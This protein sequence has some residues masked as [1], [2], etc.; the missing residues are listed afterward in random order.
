MAPNPFQRRFG[1]PALD[2][3]VPLP[4]SEQYAGVLLDPGSAFADDELRECT[5]VLDRRGWPVAIAG[6]FGSVFRLSDPDGRPVAVKCFTRYAENP[7]VQQRRYALIS[8][9]LGRLNRRWKVDFEVLSKGVL[10][11]SQWHPVLKMEWVQGESLASFIDLS[12]RRPGALAGVARAFATLV[13]ELAEDGLAHG[14]LQHGNILVQDDTKLRL[15]D[16]GGMYAPDL[17]PLGVPEKGHENFQSPA[18]EMDFGPDIDRFSAWV[19]YGSLVAL[20]LE[21]TLWVRLRAGQRNQLLF[22]QADFS[23]P[24]G[25]AALRALEESGKG[26]LQAL[27]N[28]LREIWSGGLAWIPRL[29]PTLLPAPAFVAA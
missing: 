25:S 12:L 23:D 18:R 17:E 21:P 11:G 7:G 10:V 28:A 14:D 13:D 20:T 2:G 9:L 16:Y 22:N 4:T 27:G 8:S 24:A 1:P 26:A 15:V 6:S 19:I 5:P 3:P 29:D